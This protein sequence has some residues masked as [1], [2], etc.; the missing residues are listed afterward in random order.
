MAYG[1]GEVFFED[2]LLTGG[3]RVPLGV[4]PALSLP[5][6]GL[7]PNDFTYYQGSAGEFYCVAQSS[8]VDLGGSVRP[9]TLC[10]V[11]V[12]T[13]PGFFNSISIF[14]FDLSAD[15]YLGISLTDTPATAMS[16]SNNALLP[17][18]DAFVFDMPADGTS[19]K[20]DVE[21]TLLDDLFQV[22]DDALPR[23]ISQVD[24]VFAAA[25]QLALE[26]DDAWVFI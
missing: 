12:E 18:N 21:L 23:M 15:S 14:D 25:D 20:A 24:P 13:Q 19:S 22:Q 8:Y 16:S 5:G 7:G 10:V 17:P 3:S 6:A 11:L 26:N 1:D 2:L 4:A 9:T